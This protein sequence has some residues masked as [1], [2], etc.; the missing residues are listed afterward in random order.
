MA[1]DMHGGREA[2]RSP[3]GSP[4]GGRW[5]LDQ[6]EQE[7]WGG[8]KFWVNG[9]QTHRPGGGVQETDLRGTRGRGSAGP[10]S[11]GAGREGVWAA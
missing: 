11:A 2:T 10:G 1:E 9:G 7:A 3:G 8:V 4:R 5:G 6:E